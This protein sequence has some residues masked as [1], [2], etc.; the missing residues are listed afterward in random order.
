ML[1]YPLLPFDLEARFAK[2][3]VEL[4]PARFELRTS[5]TI[6]DDG[7]MDRYPRLPD[8]AWDEAVAT[9]PSSELSDPRLRQE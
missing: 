5:G 4:P 8:S 6:R 3:Q 9:A 2:L 1:A 7:V